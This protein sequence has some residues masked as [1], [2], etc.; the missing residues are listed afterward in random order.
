MENNSVFK[1]DSC[2]DRHAETDTGTNKKE[3]WSQWGQ[4]MQHFRTSGAMKR[5]MY[6]LLDVLMSKSTY[7]YTQT[8]YFKQELKHR[9][10]RASQVKSVK[11]KANSQ[12]SFKRCLSNAY[13]CNNLELDK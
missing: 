8:S 9:Q 12:E 7:T 5:R 13:Y 4:H 10:S 3:I 2:T 6:F 1:S 11:C